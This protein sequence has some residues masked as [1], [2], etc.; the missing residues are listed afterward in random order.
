MSAHTTVN[1]HIIVGLSLPQHVVHVVRVVH[2]VHVVHVLRGVH[3][4]HGVRVQQRHRLQAMLHV[5]LHHSSLPHTSRWIA[6]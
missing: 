5:P 3:V 1:D 4:V 2:V 6:E